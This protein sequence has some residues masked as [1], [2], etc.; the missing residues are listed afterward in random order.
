MQGLAAIAFAVGL[1]LSA[2][3]GPASAQ[4][5]QT[6]EEIEK[7]YGREVMEQALDTK[8]HYDLYGIHFEFDKATIQ[9]GT[10][11]LLDDIAQTLENIP[12]W[13]LQIVGHTDST[14][15]PA[16]NEALSR[17]RAEAVKAALV[18]RGIAA[19][20]VEA[21]GAGQNQ[22]VASNETAEGRA[23]N[24]R[25]A[26]VRLDAPPNILAEMSQEQVRIVQ[27]RLAA[28]GFDP[29]APDG[30]LGEQTVTA[31]REFQE[32]YD[33]EANGEPTD[34]TLRML[35]ISTSVEMAGG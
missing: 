1:S 28:L 20:R 12:T 16:H 4:T 11:P 27:S 19:S 3:P 32:F 2:V 23:L 21:E 33:I 15:D 5:A 30:A 17:E 26:L 14:G 10:E 7:Q 9:P 6:A 29:G 8:R 18:E 22:P 25:V 34:L 24:R 35:G 31:L 13:R